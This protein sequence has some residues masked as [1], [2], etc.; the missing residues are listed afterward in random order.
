M[1]ISNPCKDGA[2][3]AKVNGIAPLWLDLAYG[4]TAQPDEN[5]YLSS[6]SD[7]VTFRWAA[8][9]QPILLSSLF[10]PDPVNFSLT[11]SRD[12]SIRANYGSGNVNLVDSSL[13]SQAFGCALSAP[14]IGI[15]NG[16]ETYSAL[17]FVSGQAGAANVVL[18]SL[19]PALRLQQFPVVKIE[20]P[21][22]NDVV[23]GVFA[24]SGIA[25]DTNS[26]VNRLTS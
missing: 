11:L 1:P 22:A 2:A 4:G 10:K 7:S 14:T 5:V 26:F 6:T 8:E 15:S 18:R 24:I 16:H 17:A 13:L 25:Y 3:L 23:Q 9:T 20:K 21:A 19:L 12:G